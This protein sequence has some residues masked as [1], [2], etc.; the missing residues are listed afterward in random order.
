MLSQVKNAIKSLK[1]DTF[2]EHFIHYVM[3]VQDSSIDEELKFLKHKNSALSS[4]DMIKV[5]NNLYEGMVT[6]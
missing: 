5:M 1:N 4:N 2:H 3:K 6:Q